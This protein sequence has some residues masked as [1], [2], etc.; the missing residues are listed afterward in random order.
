MKIK[1]SLHNTA[2]CRKPKG[3]EI[4]QI[5]KEIASSQCSTDIKEIASK[6]GEK[7]HTFCPAVFIDE[8]RKVDKFLEMQLFALDFDNEITFDKVKKRADKYH[9][10]I[11]FTYETF[12]STSENPRFRIV[13]LNDVPVTD[14]HAAK[15]MILM[16]LK[17]FDEADGA[18]KAVSNMFFGGKRLIGAVKEEYIN[19]VSLSASYQRY[20]FDTQQKNYARDIEQF[21]KDNYI[22]CINN[23]LQIYG[24]Y[25]N[26]SFEDYSE[27]DPYIYGLKT[28]F[29]SNDPQYYIVKDIYQTDVRKSPRTL[30]EPLRI[31]IETME[32]KCQLYRDFVNELH[33]H[34]NERFLLLTNL[35]HIMGG[36]K[37]FLAVIGKK[38]YDKTEWRFYAKYAKD[39]GY[40]PQMC[41]GNC[42]YAYKCNHEVN[43]VNTVKQKNQVIRIQEDMPYYEVDEVYN[44]IEK[45]LWEAAESARQGIYIIPA[46]TA[47]GKT[48]AYCDLV[49]REINQRFLI[50]VPTNLLKRE[51]G[52]RL[53]RKGVEA[54]IAM[55]LDEMNL[56]RGLESRIQFY[57]QTGLGDNVIRLLREYI[58]H[59]KNSNIPDVLY[60]VCQCKLYLKLNADMA[61]YR[62]LVMTHARLL[63]LSSDIIRQYTVIVDEDILSTIFKNTRTV[64]I[65]TIYKVFD[66]G[67]C[68]DMLKGRLRQI[69]NT[70]DKEYGRFHEIQHFDKLTEQEMEELGI[71]DNVNEILMASVFEKEDGDI[72]YF[73]PQTLKEGKYI[74]LSATIDGDLYRRYFPGKVVKEYPY[75]RAKYQGKLKQ[76]T[77]FPMSRQCVQD[78]K[79]RL[80]AFL[81]VF[82]STYKM[83]T[84]KKFESL[85]SSTGIHFGN[86]EGID[87]LNGENI[88]VMGT[89]HS[90]EFVYKLIG[91]HLGMEVE[92]E[93]LAVRRIQYKGYELN[94]MTYKNEELKNLQNFFIGK[95]LEQCIG[96]ARLLR[97]N[98]IVLVLSNFPCEQA[99]LIQNDYLI[100][101]NHEKLIEACSPGMAGKL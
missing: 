12:S 73:I 40:K 87:K 89:P 62:V 75:R 53:K 32:A 22:G 58:D 74:I 39:R 30:N 49:S 17:I 82:Q 1:L 52:E 81:T 92:K 23:C 10:P 83:I 72:H 15:I 36:K 68:P 64:P 96:R 34:H 67:K 25:E 91:F 38:N 21:A 3:K 98:C 2:F 97:N 13:F 71:Y 44:Y 46:Q 4:A 90:A 20:I 41:E 86:A 101:A 100:E 76:L 27:N 88:M 99:E 11:A 95:E 66:S 78:H 80:E 14:S 43:I 51:V 69:I 9:L 45:S 56:E 18:C 33:I 65:D 70:P 37:R 29:P 94:F 5:S 16:L 59:N 63:T 35:L 84:F 24:V 48:E 26:G 8:E 47:I 7:G 85:F 28:V 61:E 79:E 55:S 50:A 54:E 60:T 19:I 6:I 31:D 77:A 42:P 93:V 57:Y